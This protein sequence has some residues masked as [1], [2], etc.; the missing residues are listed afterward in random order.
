MWN[1]I[2]AADSMAKQ[3]LLGAVL[4]KFAT[5]AAVIWGTCN[6]YFFSYLKHTGFEVSLKT[7]SIILL[8]ALIPTSVAVLL[9]NPF[10]R[11][12]GYKTAIR[13]CAF[14]FLLSPMIIN[15]HFSIVTFAI[16]WL[17]VPLS[18]FCL[19]AIPVL[20]CIWTHFKKDLSK[21]SGVAVVAI[22]VGMIFWNILF[23]F[24]ANP[25]NIGA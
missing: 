15:I 4:I 20:N 12:V 1:M 19:G 6:V 8:C 25:D 16:F 23:L 13:I 11:L 22:S 3:T 5:G 10:A 18:C 21:I 9:S 17:V 7:N 24:I 2:S 14:V